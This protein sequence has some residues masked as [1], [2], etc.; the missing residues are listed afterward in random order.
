M[1]T[2]NLV[3][4]AV[5]MALVT[6]TTMF[7]MPLPSGRGYLNLGDGL[8][9]SFATILPLGAG[10]L[11]GGLGSA[12]SDLLLG[13]AIYAPGTLVIK[14]VEALIV[15]FIYKHS[16]KTIR[17]FLPFILGASW[18]IVM[19]SVYEFLVITGNINS[20][21]IAFVGNLPQAIGSIILAIIL[22]P[23]FDRLKKYIMK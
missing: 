1:K 16:S 12:L 19:Y 14:A 6:A 2:K 8:V 23:V 7:A 17:S 20:I 5:L 4:I 18:M 22:T 3:L 11:V 21:P 13:Y 9:M 15:Y 10:M